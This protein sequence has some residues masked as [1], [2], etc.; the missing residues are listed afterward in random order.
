MEDFWELLK[1]TGALPFIPYRCP[2]FGVAVSSLL[3]SDSCIGCH[4]VFSE[5][6]SHKLYEKIA[7]C[8]FICFVFREKSEATRIVVTKQK[9]Y[10]TEKDV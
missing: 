5:P 1:A 2:E 4:F 6:T 8:A 10:R 9:G 7:I 3:S